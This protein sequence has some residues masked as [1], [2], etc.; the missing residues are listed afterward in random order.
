MM[1]KLFAL[2]NMQIKSPERKDKN[3]VYHL[4]FV[5]PN[6]NIFV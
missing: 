5:K 3:E 6:I 2:K 1:G 4:I